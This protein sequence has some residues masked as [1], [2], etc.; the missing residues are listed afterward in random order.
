[1]YSLFNEKE[2]NILQEFDKMNFNFLERTS[3]VFDYTSQKVS[4]ISLLYNR[5]KLFLIQ[6]F[7][8][9]LK[10]SFRFSQTQLIFETWAYFNL[11]KLKF[12]IFVLF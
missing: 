3:A 4:T 5:N 11:R 9:Y 2:S 6:F 8:A 10:S 7:C 1:M 12:G